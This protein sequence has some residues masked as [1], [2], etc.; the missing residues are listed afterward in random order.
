[1]FLINININIY[2]YMPDQLHQLNAYIV[3]SNTRQYY[4][5]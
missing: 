1:M 2:I 3:T 4:D 5:F